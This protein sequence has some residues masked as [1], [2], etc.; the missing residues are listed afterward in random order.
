MAIHEKRD[1]ET[2]GSM[3]GL[4]EGVEGGKEKEE[5]NNII[6]LKIKEQK[7]IKLGKEEEYAQNIIYKNLK[8]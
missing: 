4:W 6:I 3:E 2:E 1:H 5:C 7:N 8:K